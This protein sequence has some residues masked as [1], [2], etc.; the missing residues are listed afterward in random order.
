MTLQRRAIPIPRAER[1]EPG[2]RHRFRARRVEDVLHRALDAGDVHREAVPVRARQGP[3]QEIREAGAQ[4]PECPCPRRILLDEAPAG[5]RERMRPEQLAQRRI[6]RLHHLDEPRVIHVRVDLEALDGRQ[7]PRRQHD[8]LGPARR[9]RQQRPRPARAQPRL[10]AQRMH[11]DRLHP[12]LERVEPASGPGLTR[13]PV[14][15]RPG[16]GMPS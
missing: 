6:L 3:R 2:S 11:D 16:T 15:P 14:R 10:G 8:R 9:S 7:L 12:A 13:P 1:R 4:A 5:G